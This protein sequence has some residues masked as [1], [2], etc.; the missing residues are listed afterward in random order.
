MPPSEGGIQSRIMKMLSTLKH[1]RAYVNLGDSFGVR[2]RPDIEFHVDGRTL[3]F[4]VKRSRIEKPSVMQ[5]V[6]R[7]RLARA[8]MAVYKV[9]SVAEVREI[10]EKERIV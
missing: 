2:G 7:A 3:F 4:E 10:L 5:E 6:E 8:G 1:A 9:C